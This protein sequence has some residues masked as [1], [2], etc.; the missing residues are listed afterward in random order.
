MKTRDRLGEKRK[1]ARGL[2]PGEAGTSLVELLVAVSISVLVITV[3]TS[4]LVQFLT[5]SRWGN[6]QLK[7]TNDIQVTS[8]WLGRDALEASTFTP[9]TGSEYGTLSWIDPAG[10]THAYTYAYDPGE[11]DLVRTYRQDGAVQS[12]LHVARYLADQSAAAFNLNDQLLT[13]TLTSS[14]GS[15]TK[16]VDLHYALR[17]R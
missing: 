2:I 14:S 6:D 10:V 1:A 17:P 7:I 15:E 3:V 12:T 16:T 8:I 11:K 13:V 4:S 9:G 5:V